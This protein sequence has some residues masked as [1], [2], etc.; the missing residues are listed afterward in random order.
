MN[1]NGYCACL[2]VVQIAV[3]ALELHLNII[4]SSVKILKY[5]AP[6]IQ[7]NIVLFLNQIWTLNYTFFEQDNL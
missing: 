1:Y 3:V 5:F 4:Q 7:F 2:H 6:R